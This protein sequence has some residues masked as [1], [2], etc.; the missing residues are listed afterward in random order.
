MCSK[1]WR[2]KNRWHKGGRVC[3]NVFG[4]IKVQLLP[5]DKNLEVTGLLKLRFAQAGG[6][7]KGESITWCEFKKINNKWRGG[8]LD[9]E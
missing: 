6:P 2:E 8:S 5:V 1:G 3:E 7:R 4:G 9:I